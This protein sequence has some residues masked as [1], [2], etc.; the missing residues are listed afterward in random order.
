[1]QNNVFKNL[2]K[3]KSYSAVVPAYLCLYA[4]PLK[5]VTFKLSS[6][7]A[8]HCVQTP[9]KKN[10]SVFKHL[11]KRIHF[12][13]TSLTS[14]SLPHLFTTTEFHNF[15]TSSSYCHFPHPH[16]TSPHHAKEERGQP[17]PTPQ[18]GAQYHCWWG[19]CCPN[20]I[21]FAKWTQFRCWWGCCRKCSIFNKKIAQCQ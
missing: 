11:T 20:R 9:H 6:R 18:A 12:W 15:T 13:Q 14:I 8:K 5:N 4:S 1:M 19:R 21:S 3:N 7:N 16:I 10:V 17:S 2:T